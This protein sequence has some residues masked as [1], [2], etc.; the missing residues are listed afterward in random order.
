MGRVAIRIAVLGLALAVE[1]YEIKIDGVL[2][3][4]YSNNTNFN[5]TVAFNFSFPLSDLGPN[6]NLKLFV[7]GEKSRHTHP[8]RITTMIQEYGVVWK[9]PYNVSDSMGAFDDDYFSFNRYY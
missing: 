7:S 1:G 5:K 3:T 4:L 6:D 2:G 9:L 8:I